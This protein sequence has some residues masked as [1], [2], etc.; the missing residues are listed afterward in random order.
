MFVTSITRQ[1]KINASIVIDLH[2]SPRI[3]VPRR[4]NPS[5]LLPALPALLQERKF[6]RSRKKSQSATCLV[7]REKEN[8]FPE[9]GQL[10]LGSRNEPT[11]RKG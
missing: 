7:R 4:L 8:A 2:T 10:K 11:T 6:L 1:I 9:Q 5:R 3:N